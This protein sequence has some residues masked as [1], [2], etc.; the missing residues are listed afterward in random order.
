M[1][2]EQLPSV[3]RALAL[4]G[5][6]ERI[7]E[8][9]DDWADRYDDEVG[10]ET[11]AAPAVT[12]SLVRAC[13]ESFDGLRT[14]DQPTVI[15][16]GCGTGLVGAQLA[17]LGYARLDGF[18][19]SVE[20]V[21]Q[22]RTRACYRQLWGGVDMSKPITVAPEG[23]YD[24]GVSTGVFTLGHVPAVALDHLVALVRPGGAVVVSTRHQY[25]TSA[26]FDD[27]VERLVGEG[28][29]ALVEHVAEAPYSADDTA[30]YWV[31]RVC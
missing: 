15:D 31:L 2:S 1:A 4:D 29:V 10:G 25:V 5:T 12:A 18:D 24:I 21:E 11:Y 3:A 28:R 16:A 8:F 6:P 20:M 9:Y 17:G 30:Q 7:A 13:G 26:G 19:L 22:A 14:G 23:S 27:R